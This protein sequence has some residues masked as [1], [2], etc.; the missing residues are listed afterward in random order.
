[1]PLPNAVPGVK[2]SYDTWVKP[3]YSTGK[4]Q[5]K[6]VTQVERFPYHEM[7]YDPQVKVEPGAKEQSSFISAEDAFTSRMASMM[8]MD[9]EGWLATWD[10]KSQKHLNEMAARPEF[11]K[12]NRMKQWK[13]VLAAARP[14]MVRKINTGDYSIITYK[15]VTAQGKE[16]QPFEM[17]AAFH[18][19]GG[20]WYGTEDLRTDLLLSYMPWASGKMQEDLDL[21]PLSQSVIPAKGAK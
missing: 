10:K 5:E 13:N 17:P 11:S 19:V 9:Y 1:M 3:M 18:Q 4:G 12:E 8:N 14:V 16:L 6:T 21:R 2:D 20:L 15:L 7:K